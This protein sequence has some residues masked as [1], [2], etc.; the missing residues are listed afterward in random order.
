MNLP[1]RLPQ[2]RIRFLL[3]G[4][5]AL[6]FSTQA[7]ADGSVNYYEDVLPL[8]RSRPDIRAILAEVEFPRLGLGRRISGRM[9]PALAGQRVGPYRF[10][11]VKG[12]E[13]IIVRFST[14]VRFYNQYDN[15][16]GEDDGE[17]GGCDLDLIDAVRLEEEVVSVSISRP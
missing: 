2:P 8:L 4:I 16:L 17:G 3:A 7:F 15:F 14:V 1:I 6:F 10:L 11:A 13:D 9:I 5:L 12:N